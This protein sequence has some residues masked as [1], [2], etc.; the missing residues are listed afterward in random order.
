MIVGPYVFSRGGGEKQED[1]RRAR[2]GTQS[3]ILLRVPLSPL[4]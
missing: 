1:D 3:F 2:G 4:R